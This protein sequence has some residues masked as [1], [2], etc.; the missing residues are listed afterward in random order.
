MKRLVR[1]A[2]IV[3]AG[4][5]I[6]LGGDVVQASKGNSAP[7]PQLLQDQKT[8]APGAPSVVQVSPPSQSG[9]MPQAKIGEDIR[10]IRGPISIPYPWLWAVYAGGGSLLLLIAWAVWRLILKGRPFRAKNPHEIAFERLEK[11][12]DL[13][14]PEKAE[15]FSVAVSDAIRTY[16]EKRFN[17]GVTHNS[18]EEFMRH[19]GSNRPVTLSEYGTV[20][21]DFLGH[22]DLAKFARYILSVDQM[23]AMHQS[24]WQFVEKTIPR[25]EDETSENESSVS[26]EEPLAAQY[27]K[28]RSI[29]PRIWAWG[30]R[31]IPKK[32]IIPDGINDAALMA[33]GRS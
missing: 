20:L 14:R 3:A 8:T 29:L 27:P 5:T 32:T 9:T 15:E 30:H 28:G 18:T 2:V 6:L 23:Q 13:M 31:L 1:I 22:C 12:R 33:G 11:A 19:I 10:D 17:L 24:A 16:I 26:G 4:L 7:F 25:P 21:E